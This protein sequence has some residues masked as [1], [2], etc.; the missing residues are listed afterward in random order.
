MIEA[1]L[2]VLTNA[3]EGRD[4]DFNDWYS[5]VHARDTMR[6]RGG[7]AQ[8]R[9]QFSA[10]QVQDF[11]EGFPA[12]YLA[13]YDVYDAAWFAQEH[14]D[15]ART[16]FMVIEDSLDMS[17]L[18][19]FAYYPLCFRDKRPRTF[20]NCG[21]ILEQMQV[22]PGEEAAFREWFCDVYMP[23]R[24]RQDGIVSVALMT[25]DEYGQMM[26]FPPG[27]N[28]LAI[29]RVENEGARDLWRQSNPL[30]E[31]SHIESG[32][33][34]ISCWDIASKRI[35]KDDVT[36]PDAESLAKEEAARARIKAQGSEVATG[37]QRIKG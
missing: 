25:F 7:L 31:C 21:V 12:Q 11:V 8:Q 2:V 19:D 13:L 29:W 6:M 16:R 1:Q 30:A 33:T 17:R 4:A 32:K 28:H 34:A 27:H 37:Q 18:D 24:F 36:Y 5:N 9:F 26:P 20:Q 10:D 14:M 15:R 35:I 22:K 23:E 3:V